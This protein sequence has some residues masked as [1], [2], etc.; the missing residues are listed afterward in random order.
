MVKE[1][2]IAPVAMIK[3]DKKLTIRDGNHETRSNK[4][5][6][7]PKCILRLL[8]GRFDMMHAPRSRS[9]SR[10]SCIAHHNG[11]LISRRRARLL[12]RTTARNTR[13]IHF[14]QIPLIDADV[15]KTKI[16]IAFFFDPFCWRYFKDRFPPSARQNSQNSLLCVA[17]PFRPPPWS[18][19]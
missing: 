3:R 18:R 8:H 6:K 16:P 13:R 15:S 11:I 4:L 14:Y 12:L 17:S 1:A 5:S 7:R 10:D 19:S 9:R 2:Q